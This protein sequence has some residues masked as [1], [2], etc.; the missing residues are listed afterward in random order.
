MPKISGLPALAK[1]TNDDLLAIVDDAGNITKKVT[2]G[3]F[4]AGEPLPA[5]SVDTQAIADASVTPAKRSGGFKVGIIAGSML[6]T[7]GI[8]NISGVGF[9]PQMVK[10]SV[11][12][13]GSAAFLGMAEGS[14]TADTQYWTG[15]AGQPSPIA[16]ART[17]STTACIG[18][19]NSSGGNVGFQA[20]YASMD[21]DGFSINVTTASSTFSIAYE[22]YA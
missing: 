3:D 22:A 9:K 4:I 6:S 16:M 11:L 18:W 17:H 8:K 7:T 1:A 19:M 20:Q 21:A 14:M 10:F 5:N 13:T 2:R 12:Y 15:I